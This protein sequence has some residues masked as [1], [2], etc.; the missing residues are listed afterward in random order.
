MKKSK[1]LAAVLFSTLF[2]FANASAAM[3]SLVT[4]EASDLDENFQT[5]I[6][7]S[8]DMPSVPDQA[9]DVV[10]VADTATKNFVSDLYSSLANMAAN[11]DTLTGS[12]KAHVALVLYGRGS[13][14]MFG[15]TDAATV[16]S[17][18]ITSA[19]A[20]EDNAAWLSGYSFGADLQSGVERAKSILD[21][22]TTGTTKANRHI[23]LLTDGSATLYNNAD[24]DAASVVFYGSSN[25]LKPMS[26]MD[27]NGDVGNPNRNTTSVNLL[28]DAGGD[29]AEA[30]DGLFARGSEIEAIAAKAYKYVK[31]NYTAEEKADITAKIADNSVSY[32]TEANVNDL[33][34]Y[35]FTSTEIGA[36][37][38]AKALKAAADAGYGIHTIGYLYEWGWEDNGEDY[39][40]K[41]LAIPSRGMVE[42]TDSLGELYFHQSKTISGADLADDLAE[43][44]NGMFGA[45]PIFGIQDEIGYGT[46][47]DE[48]PYNFNFINDLAKISITVDGVAL[49]KTQISDKVYE[50]KQGDYDFLFVYQ[51]EDGEAKEAVA[52][53]TQTSALS[54]K[55]IVNY[56]EEL[57]PETRKTEIGEYSNLKASNRSQVYVGDDVVEELD[58]VTVSYTI[59]SNPKTADDIM[60][61]VI[62]V[63]CVLGFGGIVARREFARRRS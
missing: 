33:S 3:A 4:R 11:L 53:I 42:W 9:V 61:I 51:E 43:I 26:N 14:T 29:Y 40:L 23:V 13:H 12:E 50:F 54:G 63:V 27:S 2:I 8:F 36:Y 6:T 32:F 57:T 47:E 58:P 60:Y 21:A 56:Y 35:P 46:Y 38:G 45:A 49:E 55:V 59:G 34:V 22:S 25:D 16:D 10:F 41:L 7:L 31:S 62:P 1:F 20:T 39:I 24:G 30:F 15:L 37:M 5:K 17:A 48:T 28:A 52:V 44:A 19:L 18:F